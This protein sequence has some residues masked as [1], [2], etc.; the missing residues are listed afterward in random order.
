MSENAPPAVG[1]GCPAELTNICARRHW[2]LYWL[3]I[4]AAVAMAASRIFTVGNFSDDGSPFFSAN[5]RSRWCTVRSLG[6]RGTF[7]IED[8][9]AD[10]ERINWST[11]D[12]VRHLGGDGQIHDYSSK[13]PLLPAL[14]G[15][16]Y[17]LI[18]WLTGRTMSK[19][20]TWIVRFV[21]VTVN[22]VPFGVFLWVFAHLINSVP[23]R[24]WTRY[25]MM[26]VAGFA[27]FLSTFVVTLNNHLPAAF[28][29]MVVLYC[30]FKIMDGKGTAWH[31]LWAGLLSAFAAAVELP[32]LSFCALAGLLVLIKSPSKTLIWW[33]PA[34]SV[35]FG[36][37]FYSNFLAHGEWGLA[38]GHRKDGA[39]IAS[40]NG[41]FGGELNDGRFPVEL[42]E[43]AELDFGAP[44]VELGQ[45]P[46][47]SP[48]VERWVVRD[49][50]G[51]N[52]IAIVCERGEAAGEPKEYQV[53]EWNNWYDYPGSYWLA[54]N[55]RK[56]LVDR[57]ES[58]KTVYLFHIL[59]GHH[60]VFSLSP[61]WIL[62]LPGLFVLVVSNRLK[63]RWLGASGLV[64][65][66]VVIGFYL[67]RP[68]L[69]RN[70]GGVTS[71]LRWLFWLV[72]FWLVGML[73]IVDWLG[74]TRSGR[75]ACFIVLALS[76]LSAG[77]SV[78]NPWVHPW[79]YEVWD[80]LPLPK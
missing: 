60:G 70:Y 46:S 42:R 20:A 78:A 38:Y 40:V 61:I 17:R 72:P 24:D 58:S 9:I 45:W 31:F 10:R 35:V 74:K 79:L 68:E 41:D 18:R 8:V 75:I 6:D 15:G 43:A 33:V 65:S 53:L 63:L 4:T 50:A 37:F 27:T 48:D 47:T 56:S 36:G 51:P 71:G 16:E 28:S 54:S 12:R 29:V 22:L 3:F 66:L 30:L 49:R 34:A 80:G 26:I 69:D 13:P 76:I 64:L 39:E 57:G 14:I 25:F 23:V 52:Q 7:E 21:L 32:A 55:D 67:N 19:D 2:S 5:D 77:Y 59:F 73:P 1:T 44:V 62:A 11:I